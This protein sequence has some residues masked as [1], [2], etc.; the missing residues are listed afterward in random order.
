MMLDVST[1]KS[2]PEGGMG[3]PDGAGSG[4]GKLP[5]EG[6]KNRPVY[7]IM[8]NSIPQFYRNRVAT[9]SCYLF[10]NMSIEELAKV[11]TCGRL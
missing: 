4:A 10:T 5:W 3:P 7:I 8:A 9:I 11:S 6:P 2:F 1:R